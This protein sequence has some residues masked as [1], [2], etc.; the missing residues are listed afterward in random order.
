[1]PCARGPTNPSASTRS[2]LWGDSSGYCG[3]PDCLA[4]LIVQD[5]VGEDAHF[6]EAAHI[7]A[8]SGSGPRANLDMSDEARRDWANLLLLCANCHALV[9]KSPEAYPIDML[10]EW[11]RS[12][13]EKTERA[14]GVSAVASREEA[15]SAIHA[16]RVQNRMI[17]ADLGPDNDYAMNPEAE[18]AAHWRRAM[19][20]TL[21]PNHRSMLRIIDVNRGLL[22]ESEVSIVEQY[23]SH[24]SDLEARHL[25]GRRGLTSRRYPSGMDRV[26]E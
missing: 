21:I 9:D 10:L 24:V 26:F 20:E 15:W 3:R 1:M 12:R 2:R 25:H 7:V 4:K 17:H 8:A 19:L 14:L 18:Q 13:I 5:P 23:R 6:A 11:K 22:T 16:L